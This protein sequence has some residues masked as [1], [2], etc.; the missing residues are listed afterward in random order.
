M[1]V[2]IQKCFKTATQSGKAKIPF[3]IL[4]FIK[5]DTQKSDSLMGWI[6]SKDT[7]QQVQLTFHTL[8]DA[9]YYVQNQ[10]YTFE[11]IDSPLPA[12]FKPKSYASNFQK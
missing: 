6:G 7:Q 4:K 3:F 12:P 1:H 10:G 2:Y 8:N 9:I 5:I 11:V